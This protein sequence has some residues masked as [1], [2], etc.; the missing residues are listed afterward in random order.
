MTSDDTLLRQCKATQVNHFQWLL[1][2]GTGKPSPGN[3]QLVHI[4]DLLYAGFT[5]SIDD[6]VLTAHLLSQ[7]PLENYGMT[8]QALNEPATMN[9]Q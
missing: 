5:G 7:E 1:S 8:W 3:K 4:F 9:C 2:V 6:S